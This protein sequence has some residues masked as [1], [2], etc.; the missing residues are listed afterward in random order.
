MAL[1]PTRV[2]TYQRKEAQ[3]AETV[4]SFPWL[5]VSV[6][7]PPTPPPAVPC[8]ISWSTPVPNTLKTL[9]CHGCARQIS[10][11]DVQQGS[12]SIKGT[13][14]FVKYGVSWRYTSVF[15]C[16]GSRG[17]GN[18]HMR[19]H[20]DAGPGEALAQPPAKIWT[21]YLI[22]LWNPF[23]QWSKI[24]TVLWII[25]LVIHKQPAKAIWT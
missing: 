4:P 23:K 9:N 12:S 20:K 22:I 25:F 14:L 1:F 5:C 7:P 10:L 3:D 13:V 8:Q 15:R 11:P 17:G 19:P 2:L 21:L 16:L 6:P 18:S 24:Y